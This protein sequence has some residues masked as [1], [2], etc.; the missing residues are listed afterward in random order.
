LLEENEKA[1]ML[2]K[3]PESSSWGFNW[4]RTHPLTSRNTKTLGIRF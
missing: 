1:Q 2:V 4:N 3:S